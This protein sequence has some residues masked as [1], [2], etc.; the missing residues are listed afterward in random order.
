MTFTG[1]SFWLVGI[2][3]LLLMLVPIVL[4]HELGHFIMA[5]LSKIR[6]LEFGLGFPPRARV[7][8]HDHETEYT[9]NY[10]PIGGFVRLEGEE[11]DSDDPR[12]FT[13][14]PLAKQLIVLLA[15]VTMNL[16]TA[17]LLFFIVAWAFNP[18]IQPT[19]TL[20]V[21]PKDMNTPARVSGLHDGET[22][23]SIDGDP[24]V[25]P[26]VLEFS[27]SDAAAPWRQ[28]LLDH[29]G[30]KVD[31][32]VA[33]ASGSTRTISVQLRIP[34]GDQHGALG[35]SLGSLVN[36]SGNPMQAAGLAFSGTGR[37]MNLILGAV[38]DIGAQLFTNP[39]KGPAGV[40]GPV[41]MAADVASVVQQPNALMLLLLI[42]G[43][44][45]A[46]L[47]LVNVL[48]FPVL[49]GGKMVIMI[50]KRMFG[51]KGVS[52]F[53]A[54]AYLASFA[55]LLAFMGWITYFDIVTKITG[56]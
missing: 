26:S 49:D 54:L 17:F 27:R 50:I 19:V 7:L 13:N 11:T 3:I 12:A 48:P 44:L 25:A 45:S 23:I 10:L 42:A 36:T 38:G 21:D 4:V 1:V 14:A 35:V 52:N 24:F 5:R 56:Q 8:G 28:Q 22:L 37:A 41:G 51:A 9:L 15:G 46:N 29:A 20:S 55:L 43:I 34:T 30:E 47:A 18:V 32:V 33:D 31:L 2:P 16:L 39:T 53:E 6:V 40:Q